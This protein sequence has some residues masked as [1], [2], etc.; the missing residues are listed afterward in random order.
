M[1]LKIFSAKSGDLCSE[2]SLF[3]FFETHLA[4]V[5][6]WDLF[7]LLCHMRTSF[8][9]ECK[10]T[11]INALNPQSWLQVERGKL[12]KFSSHSSS[13]LDSLI[14]VPEPPILPLFKPLDYVEVLAQIHEELELCPLHE[15]SN[16]YL[17]Q[18]QVFK[19]LGEVKLMRRSLRLAWQKATTVHEKLI[20]GAWLMYEKQG[21]E[22]IADLLA[23]CGKC[24][25]EFGPIDVAY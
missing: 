23:S 21:E 11:Q 25:Q 6:I 2:G 17:L 4:I 19:G 12:S 7:H 1:W 5:E 20:F 24:A 22:V 3:L 18:F 10:E 13:S 16:L 15:R 9:S 8:P 14:K